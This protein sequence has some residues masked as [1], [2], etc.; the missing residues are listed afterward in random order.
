MDHLGIGTVSGRRVNPAP[1]YKL[2]IFRHIYVQLNWQQL[3]A[4]SAQPSSLTVPE[5][6]N[7]RPLFPGDTDANQLQK[8]FKAPLH[9]HVGWNIP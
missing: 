5:M 4:E 7:G 1:Q 8:I 9:Q 3:I 6:V 2:P